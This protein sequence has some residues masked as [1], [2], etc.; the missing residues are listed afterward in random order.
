[1]LSEVACILYRLHLLV[2]SLGH[3]YGLTHT[4]ESCA[5]AHTVTKSKRIDSHCLLLGKRVIGILRLVVGSASNLSTA[6][7]VPVS[8]KARDERASL[9]SPFVLP[10]L[11]L[12]EAGKSSQT[13]AG[14]VPTFRAK[15]FHVV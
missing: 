12:G 1:M 8:D 15:G 10:F 9:T 14:H 13:T 2:V 11:L 3:T 4:T 5:W 6:K 7:G